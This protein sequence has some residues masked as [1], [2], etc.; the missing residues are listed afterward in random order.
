MSE[1]SSAITEV[2][3]TPGSEISVKTLKTDLK[4]VTPEYQ[5]MLSHIEETLPATNAACD[6][7]YKS[8]SQM[9]TVTLDITD[10]TPIRSIKHTLASIERTK[11]A[12]AEAQINMKKNE[13]KIMKKQ[14]EIDNDT[15]DLDR[16]EH[17]IE[18][19]ELMNNNRN[20]ENSAKGAIRKT[21]SY[22]HLTLPT[23]CSV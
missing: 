11:S 10:L 18:M 14:R 19:I 8:H 7:F 1:K 3:L 9:M 5:G 15:D 2:E 23:I 21:V 4:V 12:L 6:N 17:E 20:I 16:A 13:I 22:T